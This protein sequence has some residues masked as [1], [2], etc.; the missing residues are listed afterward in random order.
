MQKG[1]KI[2]SISKLLG[3]EQ[4]TPTEDF[5][6]NK[7]ED[8]LNHLISSLRLLNMFDVFVNQYYID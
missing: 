3:D 4:V 5:E 2:K 1:N 6:S 7:R 8:I